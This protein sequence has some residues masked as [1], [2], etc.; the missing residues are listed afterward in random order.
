MHIFLTFLGLGF[1]SFG[2]PTAHVAYFRRA[3]VEQRSW[4]TEE[5]FANKLAL[6]Q[7][8]PGP[9]SSQLGF[10]LGLERGGWRGA[11]AAFLGFTLPSFVLMVLA[12]SL[13]PSS[14]P[15][16]QHLFH[17]LHVLAA[18]VVADAIVSMALS[19]WRRSLAA[20]LGVTATLTLIAV[21]SSAAQMAVLLVGALWGCAL[22]RS[23]GT[24]IEGPTGN[25]SPTHAGWAPLALFAA[26]FFLS[27]LPLAGWA[28][29][30]GDYY[31]AGSLVFG[32][33]HV[34]LPLLEATAPVEP[35]VFLAGYALAQAIP[36]PMFTF[37]TFLGASS[38]EPPLLG[39][40]LTTSAIFLPGFLL[41]SGL[42]PIWERLASRPR[43]AGAIAGLNAAVVGLLLAA[44][45]DPILPAAF[46]G[47]VDA[48]A[49]A[50]GFLLLRRFKP[51][52]IAL[53]V[54]FAA[55]GLLQGQL[56]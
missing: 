1:T 22:L 10:L 3:L 42:A 28:A 11:F 25:S 19:F 50:V 41:V 38:H 15:F 45:W 37:A 29:L 49:M 18:V 24:S 35:E 47:P 51:P 9:G 33:G 46:R 43:L 4:L 40:V 8:L 55:F 52:V 23:E 20:V 2:G 39:A 17:G 36:G 32:G 16:L 56:L 34:V 30:F 31:R 44:W 5:S 48:L 6:C 13:R 26:L 27:T 54:L 53:V 7:F 14:S 21:T 12:A